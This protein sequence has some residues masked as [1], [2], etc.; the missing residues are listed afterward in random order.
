M[1][2]PRGAIKVRRASPAG[3]LRGGL[4]PKA[5]YYFHHLFLLHDDVSTVIYFGGA[6]PVYGRALFTVHQ[7]AIHSRVRR[8]RKPNLESDHYVMIIITGVWGGGIT[9]GWAVCLL[10]HATSRHAN[11]Q[12]RD[13]KLMENIYIY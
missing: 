9:R 10:W 11:A 7:P 12:N 4:L 6:K 13:G 8:E 1:P 3:W 2:P 5:Q